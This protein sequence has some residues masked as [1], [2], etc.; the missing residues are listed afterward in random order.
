[1]LASVGF[2]QKGHSSRGR[3]DPAEQCPSRQ[4]KKIGVT[5]DRMVTNV[6]EANGSQFTQGSGMYT[7][8]HS[9]EGGGNINKLVIS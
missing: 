9:I 8:S 6:G 7:V 2:D 3:D 4:L 5:S 1:M